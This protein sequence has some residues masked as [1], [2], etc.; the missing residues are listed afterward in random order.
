M[1]ENGKTFL[2]GI[3]EGHKDR[4]KGIRTEPPTFAIIFCFSPLLCHSSP[5]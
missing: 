3:A 2:V 5:R 1:G 4:E